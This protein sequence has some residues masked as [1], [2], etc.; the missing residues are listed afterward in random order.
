LDTTQNNQKQNN[1]VDEWLEKFG[2]IASKYSYTKKILGDAFGYPIDLFYS[3][4]HKEAKKSILLTTLFHGDESACMAA[5]YEVFSAGLFDNYKDLAI[6]FIPI[7]N[8][9]GFE[10]NQ[11]MNKI[12]ENPNRGFDYGV[13]APSVEGD[14]LLHNSDLL[15]QLTK[16]GFLSLHEDSD[17]GEGIFVYTYEKDLRAPLGHAFLDANI[18]IMT[19]LN[20]KIITDFE[21]GYKEDLIADGLVLNEYGDGTY[22]EMLFTDNI[23]TIAAVT[24]TPSRLDVSFEKRVELNK[25]YIKAFLDFVINE[26]FTR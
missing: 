8:P 18:N 2:A 5:L 12:G 21:K 20:G 13:E 22:E 16:D 19:P 14:I 25:N 9:T 17:V 10:L 1:N 3:K 4:R 6:S 26:N 15:F 23:C 24:E 11:R 7:V